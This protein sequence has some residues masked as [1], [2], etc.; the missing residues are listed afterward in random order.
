MRDMPMRRREFLGASVVSAV[1]LAF[2]W[3]PTAFAGRSAKLTA[4]I[5]LSRLATGTHHLPVA[6]ANAYF[7]ALEAHGVL[8]LRP[9][10]FARLA[11][12]NAFDGPRT[13]AELQ[14]SPAYRKPGAKACVEAIAAA[15]W[16]GTVPVAGGGRRVVTWEDALVWRE[17][18]RSGSCQG[19]TGSWAH[20][21]RAA[22]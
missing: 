11:R 15:W 9:S 8:K 6:H 2:G 21:G 22:G 18:H 17:V 13:L 10:E 5:R 20:P 1:A 19:A 3:A 16:S 14:H 7:E 12:I 4:F